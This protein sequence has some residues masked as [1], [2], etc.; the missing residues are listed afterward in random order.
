M[1]K[2]IP[3]TVQWKK[4]I[5]YRQ[6]NKQGRGLF[7]SSKTQLAKCAAIICLPS[8]HVHTLHERRARQLIHKLPPFQQSDILKT[9][10]WELKIFRL[11]FNLG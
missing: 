3:I 6:I 7:S 5:S 2:I 1:E 11:K 4:T 9:T 10:F 8:P